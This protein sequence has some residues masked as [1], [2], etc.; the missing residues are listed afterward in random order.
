MYEET[1]RAYDNENEGLL[2]LAESKLIENINKND[3]TAIIFYLK[4]KGKNRG[5]IERQEIDI[6]SKNIT[7]I[8]FN[9]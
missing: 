1:K 9:E 5:Y 7:G 3:D 4:T 8:T 6:E 2:D